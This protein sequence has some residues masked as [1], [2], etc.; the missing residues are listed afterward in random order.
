MHPQP[1][2]SVHP[3]ARP[4]DR[5]HNRVHAVG[6]VFAGVLVLAEER[7]IKA[8]PKTTSVGHRDGP[9]ALTNAAAAFVQVAI[10]S[11]YSQKRNTPGLGDYGA[12]HGG[13]NGTNK[14]PPPPPRPAVGAS[15]RTRKATA[16]TLSSPHTEATQSWHI[17]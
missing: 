9:P 17:G 5:L 3:D 14:R 16:A 8:S 10:S 2:G 1:P 12:G 7:A 11:C 15:P 13:G 6:V 4:S